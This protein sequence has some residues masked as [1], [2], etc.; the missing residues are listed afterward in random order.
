MDTFFNHEFA[1]RTRELIEK[2]DDDSAEMFVRFSMY[3]VY[4]QDFENN[5]RTITSHADEIHKSLAQEISK[6]LVSRG[7]EQSYQT[8]RLVSLVSKGKTPFE[9]R[10]GRPQNRDKSGKWTISFSREKVDNR[11]LHAVP[12]GDEPGPGFDITSA[13]SNVGHQTSRFQ[14]QWNSRDDRDLGSNERTYRRIGAGAELLGHLPSD[15][16]KLAGLAGEFVGSY[17]PEA[18]KVVG[19]HMRRTA[20][21]YRGTE[22][23][24]DRNLIEAQRD[25]AMK[26]ARNYGVD[27]R[28]ADF[29]P[30]MRTQA[31]QMAAVGYLESRLPKKS[32]S[33][34]QRKSGRIPPSEGVIINGDGKIITQAIGHADDHYLP[35][36]LKNLKG[37]QGGHYVRSRSS[38]GLTT[39][40]IYTGLVSGARSV[41]VVSRSGV[42][43]MEF[44]DDFRGTRRYNDKAAKMVDRYAKT[45]DAVKSEQVA[46][47]GRGP[48]LEDKA[49]IRDEVESEMGDWADRGTIEDEVKRRLDDLKTSN[50][51]TK[52]ELQAI[53]AKV[54]DIP[55]GRERKMARSEL[56]DNLMEQKASSKYRLDGEGYEVALQA[57]KEQYPYYIADVK[58]IYYK[59]GAPDD[60]RF[61]SRETD[62]GYVKPKHIRPHAALE[63]YYDTSIRGE[64][65]ASQ[66]LKGTGKINADQTHYQNWAYNPQNRKPAA[67]PEGEAQTQ[68]APAQNKPSSA[69]QKINENRVMGASLNAQKDAVKQLVQIYG[70]AASD[71]DGVAYPDVLEAKKKLDNDG[72]LNLSQTQMNKLMADLQQ[73]HEL[74]G[75]AKEGPFAA[76]HSQAEPYFQ[77]HARA[78]AMLN[79]SEFERNLRA[80]N[81]MVS[82]KEPH[83]FEE[84]KPG[85]SKSEYDALAKRYEQQA[86]LDDRGLSADSTD[87]EL[88]SYSAGLGAV[89]AALRGQISGVEAMAAVQGAKLSEKENKQVFSL[90]TLDDT[91]S[92]AKM[93]EQVANQALVQI[94][95]V[96]KLRRLKVMSGDA[97]A[98]HEAK[99]LVN[100]NVVSGTVVDRNLGS[101]TAQRNNERPVEERRADRDAAEQLMQHWEFFDNAHEPKLAEAVADLGVA[102][103]AGDKDEADQHMKT[104]RLYAQHAKRVPIQHKAQEVADIAQRIYDRTEWKNWEDED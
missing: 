87:A 62:A 32:L 80:A 102:L 37:L 50:L 89:V 43:T 58:A 81:P 23:T 88:R 61:K 93:R 26:V 52:S 86:R 74:A 67:E 36:N 70:P 1:K 40:D 101:A 104:V 59:N 90:L 42:F 95:S 44:E 35:F 21:R 28:S 47:A 94:E 75:Q 79:G 71:K 54:A 20:Y 15:K 17:G 55:E 38:G 19:P 69:A 60:P 65:K 49:Q 6:S 100:P 11:R 16:A 83:V 13:L 34:L 39:E 56:I 51:P 18:E 68:A 98:A 103:D 33:E 30:G 4:Q 85:R 45:L 48:S 46:V 14:E 78:H 92:V 3:D 8:A 12:L 25:S 53:D 96:E 63:G 2:M 10:Y 99:A 7:D 72:I 82:P 77:A 84:I 9:E 57:L 66:A 27:S 31:S 91:P 5:R 73:M 97:Q 76:M 29:T 64:N 24:P 22:R 41:T